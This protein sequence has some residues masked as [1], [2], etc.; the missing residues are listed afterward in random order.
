MHFKLQNIEYK[1]E[2][3]KEPFV[4]FSIAWEISWPGE[5]FQ[6]VTTIGWRYFLNTGV[7]STPSIAKG[8]GVYLNTHKMN[9]FLYRAI[10]RQIRH[11]LHVEDDQF[12]DKF[13]DKV[14]E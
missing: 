1:D 9:K 13:D 10:W 4:S 2:G 3:V 14:D 8:K 11:E 6:V 5:P 12:K 7:L